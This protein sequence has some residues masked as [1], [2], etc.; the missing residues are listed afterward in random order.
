MWN[1][2]PNH[3]LVFI[4]SCIEGQCSFQL[5]PGGGGGGGGGGCGD[6]LVFILILS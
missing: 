4:F 3:S 6:I 1:F 5:L 2:V